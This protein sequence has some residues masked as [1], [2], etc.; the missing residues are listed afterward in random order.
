MIEGEERLRALLRNVSD[1]ITVI[2]AEGTVIWQSGNPGGTLGMPDEFWEG[3]VGF[4]FVHPD[5]VEQMGIWLAEL[6]AAPGTEVRGEYRIAAPGDD[7]HYVDATAVNLIDDPLIGGIVIT[8]RNIDER[9]RHE[10]ELQFHALHDALTGLPNRLLLLD[11]LANA[12]DRM[13][14]RDGTVAVIFCDLDRFKLVNDSLGHA[15]GDEVL[16]TFAERLTGLLRPGDTVARFGGDEFI[17]LCEDVDDEIHAR[18]I[19]ARIGA[20][21]AVPFDVG[22]TEV[23]LTASIGVALAKGVGDT[24][25]N[26]LRDADA[27]MYRAK[28]RGR[29]RIEVFDRSIHEIAVARLR[30][31]GELR[32]ALA[33]AEIVP[34]S[35]PIVDLRTR[36]VVGVEALARW[37]HPTRGLLPPEDFLAVAEDSGLVVALDTVMLERAAADAASWIKPVFL[38]VNLSARSIVGGDIVA[39]IEDVVRHWPAER[40][41]V[42]L[43]E[44]VL[45]VDDAALQQTL[46]AIRGL[47]V[48]IVVDDF[49][50][51]FSSLGYLH[52]F[53]VDAVKIDRSFVERLDGRDSD[54]ALVAAVIG[55]ADALGL[56]TIGEGVETVAQRD[57]LAGLGCR[58]AQGFLFS[59]PVEAA[60]LQVLLGHDV[61]G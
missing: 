57:T 20:A 40:L 34:H 17:V 1:T 42:E 14:R 46:G 3:R 31:E 11:R 35:E 29:A 44:G 5:D 55:M 9:K 36:A 43:T 47:G 21:L 61:A 30:V 33:R 52:R 4:D 15:P 51:G 16:V 26:L 45:L 27:A 37:E 41:R 32:Q 49:G 18:T 59:P 22:G 50:T 25:E 56:E 54:A 19:A 38:S 58:T 2:D 28:E 7:W 48:R 24:A 12:L 23:V 10:L 53:P 13:P 39:V 60:A 6:L 8:T